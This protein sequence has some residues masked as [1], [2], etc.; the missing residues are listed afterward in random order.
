ML[1]NDHMT[2]NV[3]NNSPDYP[4]ACRLIFFQAFLYIQVAFVILC[5][6][7]YIRHCWISNCNKCSLLFKMEYMVKIVVDSILPHA[8]FGPNDHP[9]DAPHFRIT[10][11][12]II[13]QCYNFFSRT[14]HNKYFSDILIRNFLKWPLFWHNIWYFPVTL[15]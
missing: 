15:E 8:E 10:T 3:A 9:V 6:V 12:T 7:L 13:D 4:S 11:K 5:L 2:I 1:K 14:T